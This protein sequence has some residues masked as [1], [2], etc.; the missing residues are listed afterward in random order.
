MNDDAAN[1]G[2]G[3]KVFN[4]NIL[5]AVDESAN[6]R[7]AVAY[8]GQLLGGL[9]GFNVMLLHVVPEPEED[10]F[11][12]TE[13]KEK[14][15]AHYSEKVDGMLADY[16][17]LLIEKGFAPDAVSVRSTLRYCPSMAACILSERDE[18][19]YS[20][21]VVGR[22]GLSRSEEFLFGSISSKIVSHAR[23]CTIW[24]VE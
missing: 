15:L 20:T 4:R 18:T 2:N 23:K 12:S 19:G 3:E 10:F 22:Q 11:P 24:V 21:I 6:A 17:Q 5:I 14:W 13:E 7:R 1:T 9:A 8:V 16:R